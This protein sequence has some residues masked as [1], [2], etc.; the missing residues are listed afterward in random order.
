MQTDGLTEASSDGSRSSAWVEVIPG[1]DRL[2]TLY[3]SFRCSASLITQAFSG[4]DAP[5]PAA[6]DDP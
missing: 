6:V 3:S 2:N 5:V 1:I 4:R